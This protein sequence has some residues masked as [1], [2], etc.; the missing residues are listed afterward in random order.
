[1]MIWERALPGPRVIDI[2]QRKLKKTVEEWEEENNMRWSSR[3]DCE[4]NWQA[5][6]LPNNLFRYCWQQRAFLG[7]ALGAYHM[8]DD[9]YKYGHLLGY[10][11]IVN[12]QKYYT[13]AGKHLAWPQDSIREYSHSLARPPK[14]RQTSTLACC[15]SAMINSQ[16]K[17]KHV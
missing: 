11:R 3:P 12:P 6:N 4:E 9:T 1:L 8:D 16:Y 2:H 7:Q 10:F 15:T 14:S 5:L 13:S 17:N